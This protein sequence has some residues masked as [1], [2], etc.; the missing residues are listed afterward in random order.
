MMTQMI[1]WGQVREPFGMKALA[2]RVYR[3]DIY[4]DAVAAI[5]TDVPETDA[6]PEGNGRFFGD[7]DYFCHLD[8]K[9]GDACEPFL[10]AAGP[11]LPERCFPGTE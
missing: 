2:K 5:E 7:W 11:G 8:K 4:R 6:K 1:R 3:P 10:P 9:L